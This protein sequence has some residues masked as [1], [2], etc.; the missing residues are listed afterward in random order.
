MT[1]A[2]TIKTGRI[3]VVDDELEIRE[4]IKLLLQE[5]HYEVFAAASG[6][7]ALSHL[8]K[9]EFAVLVT[10]IRMPGM[11]GIELI[12]KSKRTRES[13]QC[14]V[15]TGHGDIDSAVMA[16]RMGAAGYLQKPLDFAELEATIALALDKSRLVGLVERQQQHLEQ[17]VKE[18]TQSLQ[19]ANEQLRHEIEVLKDA[20][21]KVLHQSCHDYLTGLP[22]RLF[23]EDRLFTM[24]ASARR[25]KKKFSIMVLDFNG[26]KEVNDRFGHEIDARVLQT[27]AT[28]LVYLLRATDTII[29]MGGDTFLLLLPDIKNKRDATNVA[30]KVR[31]ALAAPMYLGQHVESISTS[32]GIATY[33]DDGET[34]DMLTEKAEKEVCRM[35]QAKSLSP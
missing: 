14:I 17:L 25:Y 15:I 9:Q 4:Y 29:R 11:S 12:R 7:E 31:A 20:E 28:R 34:T 6:E 5:H 18:R 2:G 8:E 1:A 19:E 23:L 27:L 16:L 30:E 32:I 3:I 10:D 35:R 22:N 13:L 26:F 33:P 21:K 24:V